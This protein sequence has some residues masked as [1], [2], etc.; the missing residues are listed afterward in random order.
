[1][2]CV[3]VLVLLLC[4]EDHSTTGSGLCSVTLP[5][6]GCC[7]LVY[8]HSHFSQGCHR[9]ASSRPTLFSKSQLLK[10]RMTLLAL[11]S[12]LGPISFFFLLLKNFCI[13]KNFFYWSHSSTQLVRRQSKQYWP[14]SEIAL[15]RLPSKWLPFRVLHSVADIKLHQ[16]ASSYGAPTDCVT[17]RPSGDKCVIKWRMYTE[18][19]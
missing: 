14:E 19:Q 7:L 4:C 18:G 5:F 1:M 13:K 15:T 2:G 17:L 12:G 10:Q 11:D 3:F 9:I 8:T 6:C 16:S